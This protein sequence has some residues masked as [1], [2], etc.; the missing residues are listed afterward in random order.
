MERQKRYSFIKVQTNKKENREIV[1]KAGK[2]SGYAPSC[3]NTLI[4]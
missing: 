3:K 2:Q 4:I 1:D